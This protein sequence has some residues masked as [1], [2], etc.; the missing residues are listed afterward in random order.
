M[1]ELVR[2]SQDVPVELGE[3]ISY[4]VLRQGTKEF[5]V[6]VPDQTIRDLVTELTVKVSSV[7]EGNDVLGGPHIGEGP[8]YGR[9]KPYPD[10]SR[11]NDLGAQDSYP[12]H[13]AEPFPD[14]EDEEGVAQL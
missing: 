11:D 13:V 9:R 1:I 10:E 5:R 4:L 12:G 2:Y 8:S 14:D 6:R 7:Q 3:A